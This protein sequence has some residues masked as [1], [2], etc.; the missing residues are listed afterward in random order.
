MDA[1]CNIKP[2]W[3]PEA[4]KA[5]HHAGDSGKDDG[6]KVID[7]LKQQA[8]PQNSLYGYRKKQPTGLGHVKK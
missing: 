6:N 4:Y 1:G 2:E 7:T 5:P 8:L 3:V